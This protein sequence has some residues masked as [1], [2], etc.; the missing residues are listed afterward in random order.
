[1]SDL[2]PE[3]PRDAGLPEHDPDVDH[4]EGAH[5]LANEAYARLASRG[6]TR[7]EVFEWTSAYL[8]AEGSGDVDGLVEF[9][10]RQED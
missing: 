4:D 10:R 7:D 2:R 6:F 8:E 3:H 1:V 9:I 5:L